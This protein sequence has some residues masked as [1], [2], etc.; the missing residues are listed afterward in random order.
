MYA[1]FNA[2]GPVLMA[3]MMD[4]RKPLPRPVPDVTTDSAVFD[5]STW[6][7]AVATQALAYINPEVRSSQT[8]SGCSG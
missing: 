5:Y 7:M 6:D 1:Y 2:N 4:P 3:S 8:H